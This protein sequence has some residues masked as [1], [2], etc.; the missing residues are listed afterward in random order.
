MARPFPFRSGTLPLKLDHVEIFVPSRE[1]AADW[2]AEVLGFQVMEEHRDWAIEGGPLMISNDGGNTMLAL[3]RGPAQ[4]Q[5]PVQGL[6][7]IAFRV[8]AA[9][10]EQFV[11]GSGEWREEPL[12]SAEVKDH[13]KALSAYFTD[14]W[15]TP[16]EVTTYEYEAAKRVLDLQA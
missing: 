14:P 16:L 6:R 13:G 4:D 5:Q 12:G 11:R 3:F 15:G 1:R 8:G 10:F 9:G 7:R 2:Y